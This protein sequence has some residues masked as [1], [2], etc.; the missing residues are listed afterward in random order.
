MK[1]KKRM[2]WLSSG[3]I[4]LAL[5]AGPGAVPPAS[6]FSGGFYDDGLYDDDWYFDYYDL[7]AE[8][9]RTGDISGSEREYEA[10][11][12]YEDAAGSGL[13]ES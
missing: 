10:S 7:G 1:A 4:G 3:L 8:D 13:F 9:G 11:Q 12:F 5:L 2:A 6:A